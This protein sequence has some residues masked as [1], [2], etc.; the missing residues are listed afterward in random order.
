[1]ACKKRQSKFPKTALKLKGGNIWVGVLI[2]MTV[3]ITIGLALTSNVLVTLSQSK[4]QEQIIL[5]GTIADGAVDRAVWQLNKSAS[6]SGEDALSF[7]EN[8]PSIGEVDISVTPTADPLTKNVYV[9]S[10]IPSKANPK[11]S[12]QIRA[13]ISAKPNSDNVSFH[14]AVQ[15]GE[16]GLN[17]NPN[18]KINGTVYSNGSVSGAG[19]IFSDTYAVGTITGVTVPAPYNKFP[20][21]PNQPMPS[22]DFNAW[23]LEANMNDD[24]YT[25]D[26]TKTSGSLGPRRIDGNCDFSNITITGPIYCS[27]S[28]TIS[29]TLSISPL[30]GSNGT[31]LLTDGV[32]N[33]NGAIV[34]DTGASPKGYLMFITSSTDANAA[35]TLG[36]WSTGGV[37]LANN[38]GVT[39][40][41]HTHPV[42]VSGYRFNMQPNSDLTCDAGLG[43]ASFVNGPG[44]SWTVTEY[45]IC[46]NLPGINACS[47]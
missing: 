5:A 3:L 20:G 16:G 42:I 39:V 35:V 18:S 46:K 37:F 28:I 47:M 27:G 44:G 45:Q 14:Y 23:K 31:V 15:V 34:N 33:N 9:K 38:G 29:G 26:L 8:G 43:S 25:G 41:P 12:R 24:A 10:Y 32:I 4:R 11:A 17:M 1:M 36:N 22:I 7:P 19:T 40:N 21:S 6:Y 30:F 2:L 13:M